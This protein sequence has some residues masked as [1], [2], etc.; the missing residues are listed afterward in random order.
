[1]FLFTIWPHP[2]SISISYC[3]VPVDHLTTPT[4]Y[5]HL[6]LFCSCGPFDHTHLLFP[7]HIVLFLLIILPHPP[8]IST[9]YWSVPID[10]LTTLTSYCHQVFVVFL[11]TIWPHLPPISTKYLL[12]SYGP[13]DHTHFIFPPSI[14]WVPV[15]HLTTPTSYF[16]QVFVVFLLT[17]CLHPPSI[18]TKY[19]LCSY[20]PFDHTHLLFPPSICYVPIDHLTTPTS[21]FHQ[22][23]VQFLLT[24]WP[25]PLHIST[26]Y[27]LCFYWPFSP[28]PLLIA[29]SCLFYPYFTIWPHPTLSTNFGPGLSCWKLGGNRRWVWSNGQ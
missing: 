7:P 27:L 26:K 21:Y 22:V 5:F 16:H 15:D 3:C 10:H 17:V 13:F 28:H 29:V 6:I 25:H 2:P 4:S 11:L 18:S 23:F 1:M 12:W 14:C 24:I 9:S 20:W 19:L 8:P